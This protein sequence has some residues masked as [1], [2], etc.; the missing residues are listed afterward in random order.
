VFQSKLRDLCAHGGGIALTL[1]LRRS[2][3]NDLES[4]GRK[5]GFELPQP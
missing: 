4:V 2:D 3:A 5:A 1:E